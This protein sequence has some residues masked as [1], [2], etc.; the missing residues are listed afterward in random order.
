MKTET[1]KNAFRIRLAYFIYLFH[2]EP[3][4]IC[5]LFVFEFYLAC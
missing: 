2:D 1:E 4:K 3:A 5:R